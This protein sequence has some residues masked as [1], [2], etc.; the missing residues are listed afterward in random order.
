MIAS[1]E[2]VPRLLEAVAPPERRGIARD[3][4]RM[5]VTDRRKHTHIHARFL[6]L[7]E[8]L[9]AGDLLIVNDSAT[10][11]AALDARRENGASIPLHVSSKIDERLWTVEPRGTVLSGEEL[12]LAGGATVV[13]IAPVEPQHPRLWYAWFDLPLPMNDY[14]L[15]FGRP[16]TYGYVSEHFPLAEYQTMFAKEYGSS[17]MPSAARPFTP[18][19]LAALYERGVELAPITLHC[20]VASFEAPERPATERYTVSHQTARAVNRAK[21]E[22]RRVIAVGTT[23]LRALESAAHDED[24]VVA[25]SGWTDL[26][27]EPGY[28]PKAVDALLTGFHDTAATHQW[29]L[30]AFLDAADLSSA[31]TEAA[32]CGYYQHEFGDI[33]LIV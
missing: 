10:L 20:G 17:E 28:R 13:P 5:L 24:R 29:I 8:F 21:A 16:I 33:H 30:R 14:L 1:V 22:S 27:I 15:R 3:E 11:P 26:V 25:S 4:V 7:A 32:E 2:Q 23:A 18:R 12:Q 6:R 31:Y 9:R 19:V